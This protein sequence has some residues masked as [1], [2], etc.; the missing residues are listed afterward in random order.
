M[1][2]HLLNVTHLVGD[3]NARLVPVITTERIMS[4]SLIMMDTG[5]HVRR[6]ASSN[7]SSGDLKPPSLVSTNGSINFAMKFLAANNQHHSANASGNNLHLNHFNNHLHQP[8]NSNS[9][10]AAAPVSTAVSIKLEPRV[11]SPCTADLAIKGEQ[12][13]V[14]SPCVKD[15]S[16]Y[17]AK[18]ASAIGQQLLSNNKTMMSATTLEPGHG[19]NVTSALSLKQRRSAAAAESENGGYFPGQTIPN[20]HSPSPPPL[21]PNGHHFNNA[22]LGTHKRD[23]D[24]AFGPSSTTNG[25]HTPVTINVSSSNNS[26]ASLPSSTNSPSPPPL[27]TNGHLV[28]HQAMVN[29]MLPNGGN[30]ASP[31]SSSFSD[32]GS[33]GK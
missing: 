29:S 23:H 24:D 18:S 1:L 17:I 28:S 10:I 20:R 19:G 21:L 12:T 32:F 9:G 33:T 11:P 3:H 6:M 13:I 16:I 4:T 22:F 7:T 25:N 14:P 2:N 26:L 8:A 27:L 15:L 31:T 30:I 5:A